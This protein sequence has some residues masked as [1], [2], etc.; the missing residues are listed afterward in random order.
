MSAGMVLVLL[1]SVGVTLVTSACKKASRSLATLVSAT[2][3]VEKNGAQP[4]WQG[5]AIGTAFSLGDAAR[6]GEGAAAF[7]LSGGA[8]LAM[9]PHTVLRFGGARNDFSVELGAV[10]LRGAGAFNLEMGRVE[11]GKG[12]GVRIS[13]SGATGTQFDLLMGDVVVLRDGKAVALETGKPFLLEMGDV[14]IK[15]N[16]VDAAVVVDA[17]SVDASMAFVLGEISIS[18]TGNQA[19][20]MSPGSKAWTALPAGERKLLAGTTLRLGGRTVAKLVHA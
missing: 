7:K 13:R 11:I 18:I 8:D 15:V 1:I 4:E 2:G 17:V 10:E 9:A 16:A 6:T 3:P 14:Q 19:E 5:A 12:G 20:Y